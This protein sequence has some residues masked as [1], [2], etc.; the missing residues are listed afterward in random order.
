V[1]IAYRHLIDD[2]A[3]R[4]LANYV[5]SGLHGVGIAL[6]V[7]TVQAWFAVNARSSLGLALRRLPLSGEIIVRSLVMT[8]ALITVG[9][10]LQVILYEEPL[11]KGWL[12]TTLPRIVA[13]GFAISLVIGVTTETGRLIGG[14]VLKSIVLGTYHRPAR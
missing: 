14:P 13:L 9:V 10:C 2:V 6:A 8:T 7:W 11:P 4:D 5:R 12:A 3:E 1:G